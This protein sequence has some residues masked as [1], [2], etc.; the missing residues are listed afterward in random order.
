MTTNTDC[1]YKKSIIFIHSKFTISSST[2]L[3]D[4]FLLLDKMRSQQ[5]KWENIHLLIT[6]VALHFDDL[7]QVCSILCGKNII[8]TIRNVTGKLKM[9][10]FTYFTKTKCAESNL[11]LKI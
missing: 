3:P 7:S 11:L 9:T 8:H 10:N 2:S 6:A 5:K 4:S 1:S